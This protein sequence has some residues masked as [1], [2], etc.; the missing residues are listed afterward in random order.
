M[1]IPSRICP[2][3]KKEILYKNGKLEIGYH[4]DNFIELKKNEL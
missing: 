3:C 1:K 4:T 2:I